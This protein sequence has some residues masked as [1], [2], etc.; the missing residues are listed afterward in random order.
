M[1]AL[2]QHVLENLDLFQWDWYSGKQFEHDQV[3]MVRISHHS[4]G[5]EPCRS[6]TVQ[7]GTGLRQPPPS[8]NSRSTP[9]PFRIPGSP[10]LPLLPGHKLQSSQAWPWRPTTGFQA[11]PN[12]Y[13]SSYALKPLNMCQKVLPFI[14]V[15][16]LFTTSLMKL[17]NV[18]SLNWFFSQTL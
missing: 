3:N 13:W 2:W 5:T 4:C 14:R 16:F 1:R 6:K 9:V 18:M 17:M 7:P 15:L 8:P 10:Q 12:V 11:N